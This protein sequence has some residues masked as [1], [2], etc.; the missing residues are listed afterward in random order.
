MENISAA[1]RY[2]GWIEEE[3]EKE[4]FYEIFSI[5]WI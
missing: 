2:V 5:M 3:K 1:G 4:F